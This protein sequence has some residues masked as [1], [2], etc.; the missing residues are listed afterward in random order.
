[1]RR[2]WPV[3]VPT[4]ALAVFGAYVSYHLLLKH[5]VKTSGLSWFD[6]TCEA[7]EEA[8]ST[9]SC[10]EVMATKWGTFPPVAEDTPDQERNRPVSVLGFFEM[11]PRPV[12]LFG[13]M[14][15][16]AMAAWYIAVGRPSRQRR[17][18]HLLV[19]LVNTLGVGG[20][21]FFV[22]LMSFTDMEAW[23]PW[24]MV[25]HACNF[26]M[27][28][29]AILLWPHKPASAAEQAS[30]ADQASAE[31]AE[32]GGGALEAVSIA[33][34]PVSLAAHPTGRLVFT[35]FGCM[36]AVMAAEWYFYNY[37][38]EYRA[39]TALRASFARL[40]KEMKKVREHAGTLYSM[41]AG[42]EK[43]DIPIREDDPI[44]NPGPDHL[45]AVVISDFRCPHCGRFARY[46]NEVVEPMFDGRLKVI[47]KHYPAE[48]RC[49]QYMNRDMHPGACVASRA[50]EA[51]RIL[52]GSKAFWKAH[53]LLF[54]SER[55]FAKK[56]FYLR[57]ADELGLD[58]RQF[59]ETMGSETVTERIAEDIE[60]A[61]KIGL[62]GTPSLYLSARLVPSLAREQDL[63]W[64]EVKRRYE[65][66]LQARL[67]RQAQARQAKQQQRRQESPAS[68]P[69]E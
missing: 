32:S 26:L 4:I 12:G 62:R 42:N 58:Q 43:K 11:R 56:E 54:E 63:F 39:R 14:Y 37:A 61:K 55:E 51:A 16:S 17:F 34:N 3:L 44:K 48:K 35:A 46:M 19:L 2:T 45:A 22:Y 13:M 1:M 40:S 47:F 53:D 9:R 52:G 5:E 41:Y 49:N 23:C 67:Q 64:K 66:I 25:A 69:E 38:Y 59:L 57:L 33:A 27:L 7:D 28:V 20:A 8:E 6:A 31:T 29:G 21:L 15:F 30:D 18:W 68:A 50:A 10:D 65:R 60:L 36:V 24:C